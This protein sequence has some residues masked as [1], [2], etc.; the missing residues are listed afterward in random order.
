MT[1]KQHNINQNVQL[2]FDLSPFNTLALQSQSSHYIA[3][4]NS[5]QIEAIVEFAEAEKL[6]IFV[7]SGGSNIVLPAKMQTLTVRMQ[8][9]GKDIVEQDDHTVLLKVQAG[10]NWHEF[11]QWC[12]VNGYHGLENLALIP[13]CVG[14]SP[15]QNIGAYGVEVGEFIAQIFAYDL[16]QKCHVVFDADQCQFGYRESL[17]K[18]NAGRYIVYA[19]SFRLLKKA[20]FKLN[21]A[22][23]AQRVGDVPSPQ[24]L[25][26]AIVAIRQAKLPDPKEFPNTG[27]FF[28]NPVLDAVQFAEFIEKHPNAPHY[29]LTAQANTAVK[30]A[31]GWLIEQAGWKGKRLGSVGM[32]E[33]QAL[34]LVN[35]AVAD[36]QDVKRTYQ[37][38]QH[39]IYQKFAIRLEPE[40]VLLGE[41]GTIRSHD[42]FT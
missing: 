28:K 29:K 4:T 21:Y 7:L 32:F 20:E 6:S 19:V 15:I 1:S 14:A 34:V 22:D 42:L 24:K 2:D 10:E 13:G 23:V 25:F 5:S 33:R 16:T 8:N 3:L 17:F 37:Q 11:V 12:C 30:V 18:R 38:I 41:D 31:A 39:D 35:Y 26:D 40:P 9:M 36:Q 27:S